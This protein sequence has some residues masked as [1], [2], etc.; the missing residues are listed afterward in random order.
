[1]QSYQFPL[2]GA[3]GS[4]VAFLLRLVR[5][6]GLVA[7]ARVDRRASRRHRMMLAVDQRRACARARGSHSP[8]FSPPAVAAVSNPTYFGAFCSSL[9]S[10]KNGSHKQFA[11][12]RGERRGRA[13]LIAT[14]LLN[15]Q[16]HLGQEQQNRERVRGGGLDDGDATAKVRARQR[17]IALLR[18]LGQ[19]GE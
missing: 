11:G 6:A 5:K 3:H 16:R 4:L 18:H 12:H 17:Q 14:H 1:M 8:E 10:S 2:P 15:A 19:I 13:M 7:P 9:V